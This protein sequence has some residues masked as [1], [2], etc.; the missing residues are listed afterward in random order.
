MKLLLDNNLSPR[1]VSLLAGQFSTILHVRALNL[2][3]AVDRQVWDYARTNDYV[4]VSNDADFH[5]MSFLF[6]APP[7][8]MWIRRGTAQQMNLLSYFKIASV[9]SLRLSARSVQHFLR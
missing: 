5:Q 7:K 3:S 8:V 9:R 2:A 4:I 6:G 1:L